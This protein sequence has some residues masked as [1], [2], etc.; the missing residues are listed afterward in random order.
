MKPSLLD[1]YRAITNI[2]GRFDLAGKPLL[3][4][5]DPAQLLTMVDSLSGDTL[6]ENQQETVQTLRTAILGLAESET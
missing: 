2:E 3:A 5:S 1:Y 4:W 6:N